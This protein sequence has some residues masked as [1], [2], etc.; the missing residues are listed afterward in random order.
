MSFNPHEPKPLQ[1]VGIGIFTFGLIFCSMEMAPSWGVFRLDWPPSTYYALMALFGGVAG[2][3]IGRGYWLPGWVGGT[4]AGLGALAALAFFLEGTTRTHS[5]ILILIAG[6]GSLPGV[7]IG[8]G[9]KALQ[10]ALLPPYLPSRRGEDA[11]P[12]R[13]RPADEDDRIQKRRP[14]DDDAPG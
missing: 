2:C 10:D 12:S 14:R 4:V 9:L 7:G 6:I 11:L 3:L 1:A 5:A 8:F 13:R